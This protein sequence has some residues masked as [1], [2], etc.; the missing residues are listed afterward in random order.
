MMRNGEHVLLMYENYGRG[1]IKGNM[2]EKI[3][4]SN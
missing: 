2:N 3:E 1:I 4:D